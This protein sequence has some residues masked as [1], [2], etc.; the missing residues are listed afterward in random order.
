MSDL[1][2]GFFVDNHYI[3]AKKTSLTWDVIMHQ[4]SHAS[5][6]VMYLTD[7]ITLRSL[8]LGPKQE[9]K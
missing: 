1:E 6:T 2:V 5:S 8:L 3:F 4:R 7:I 9:E